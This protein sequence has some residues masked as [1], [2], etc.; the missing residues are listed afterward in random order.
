MS[1]AGIEANIKV[2]LRYDHRSDSEIQT[3][4]SVI[5]DEEINE[6]AYD[7]FYEFKVERDVD[8]GYDGYW[9]RNSWFNLIITIKDLRGISDDMINMHKDFEVAKR[10]RER[11][12]KLTGIE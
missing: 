7:G 12:K 9:E 3:L 5:N 2:E 8:Y 10:I 4:M 6:E 1:Q 11:I